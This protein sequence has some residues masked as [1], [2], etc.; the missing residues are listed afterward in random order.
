MKIDR[1]VQYRAWLM[2]LTMFTV[3]LVTV[4][5]VRLLDRGVHDPATGWM[6]AGVLLAWR[7]AFVGTWVKF[8]RLR[9]DD[10]NRPPGG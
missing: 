5:P 7:G 10:A 4:V 1:L 2:V 3:A 9:P 8:E 6:A